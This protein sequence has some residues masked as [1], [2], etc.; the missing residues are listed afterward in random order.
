[1][2]A[3][4]EAYEIYD[5]FLESIKNEDHHICTCTFL[6]QGDMSPRSLHTAKWNS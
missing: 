5:L 2:I 4:R 1:M 3:P 6:Q